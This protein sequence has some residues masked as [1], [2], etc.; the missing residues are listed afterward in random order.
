[1]AIGAGGTVAETLSE[2][3]VVVDKGADVY[4][5]ANCK[6]NRLTLSGRQGE[7]INLTLDVEGLTESATGSSPSEPTSA[8]PYWFDDVVLTI[9]GTAYE[10]EAFELVVDNAI[11]TDR[12]QMNATRADLPEGDRMVTLRTE[13]S[14]STNTSGLHSVA[15]AGSNCTLVLADGT[16][17]RTYTFAKLQSPDNG[18]EVGGKGPIPLIKNWTARKD[19]ATKEIAAS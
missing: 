9:G 8:T 10:V 2:F 4:T 1:L 5:Y 17:T 16:T 13:H 12:F 14:Y 11:I 7:L 6:V 3:A 15:V 18:P 19:G